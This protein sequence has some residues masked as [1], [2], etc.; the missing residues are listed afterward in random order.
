MSDKTT[1][2]AGDGPMNDGEQPIV[3]SREATRIIYPIL[4]K[5]RKRRLKAQREHSSGK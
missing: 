4:L 2:K 3:L 5:A 1:P